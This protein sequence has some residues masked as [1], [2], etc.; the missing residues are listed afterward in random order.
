MRPGNGALARHLLPGPL[1]ESGGTWWYQ[2]DNRCFPVG[3]Q[4]APHPPAPWRRNLIGFRLGS[5]RSYALGGRCRRL[6]SLDHHDAGHKRVTC[7]S[8]Q[9]LPPTALPRP[10]PLRLGKSVSASCQPTKAIVLFQRFEHWGHPWCHAGPCWEQARS[11][12]RNGR[13][14]GGDVAFAWLAPLAPPATNDYNQPVLVSPARVTS[15]VYRGVL[16]YN[17]AQN[18][19]SIYRR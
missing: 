8:M 6:G 16:A 19:V 2:A 3:R 17:T 9:V 1:R 15:D 11:W 13:G 10:N 7:C 4:R 12:F 18:A 5:N 14:R